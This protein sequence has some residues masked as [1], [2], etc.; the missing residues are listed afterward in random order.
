MG[1]DNQQERL[2]PKWIAGFVDGEGCFF[3]G[4]NR[5]PTMRVGFQV[6]PEFRVVQH[7]RDLDVLHQLRDFFGVGAAVRNHGERYELR[8][9]G[10]TNLEK[11]VD[12][13]EQHPLKTG[14]Q[15]DFIAF[16]NVIE[17]MRTKEHL[18]GDG[19]ER[20]RTIAS[21]MNRQRRSDRESSETSTSDIAPK[22]MKIQSDPHG[23]M[24]RSSEMVAR[25]ANGEYLPIG[26]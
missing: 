17:M 11:V 25:H 3:I 1:A 22:A 2:D 15:Q 14:K 8:I 21:G 7:R 6:L 16:R 24:R 12:F 13:F 26:K 23:D 5:Q 4:I 10:R 19:L 20:I 18:T 9:R